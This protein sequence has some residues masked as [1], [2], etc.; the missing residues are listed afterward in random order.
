MRTALEFDLT[1]QLLQPHQRISVPSKRPMTLLPAALALL[2]AILGYLDSSPLPLWMAIFPAL[3]TGLLDP[4]RLVQ[5]LAI[6]TPIFPVLR[7]ASD[8]VGAQQVSTK[9]LFFSADD[10]LILALAISWAWSRLRQ[11]REAV[12]LFPSALLALFALYPLVIGA[13]LMR[14]S[15]DQALVSGLYYIKWAEYAIL[16][17]AIPQVIPESETVRL[18]RLFFKTTLAALCISTVFASYEFAEALRTGSYSVS[19]SFP[20]ASAFFGTLDPQRFGASEDPVNFGTYAMVRGAIAFSGLVRSRSGK[21]TA[22]FFAVVCGIVALL[23]SASRAPWL[24]ALAA[25]GKIRKIRSSRLVL[26]ALGLLLAGTLLVL[27][28]PEVWAISAS[29]FTALGDWQDASESSAVDRLTIAMNSPVFQFDQYWILGHGHSSYR[30]IAEEH[31]SRIARGVSRSLY[32]FP[33]TVWYDVGAAGC[34]LWVLFFH[35]LNRRLSG[36]AETCPDDEV[37]TFASGIRGAFWGIAVAA[38]FGEVPYNW[39]VMGVFYASAGVCLAADLRSR[40][41]FFRRPG[42][43]G[44]N[45]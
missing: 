44:L 3:W 31:L 33:L 19:A 14:L 21:K 38:M 26:S 4:A 35:Q 9:G 13:N 34:F 40:R 29:R 25:F 6:T 22:A 32:N 12:E 1:R 30:F 36:I 24:S 20:R 42:Y 10:P 41:L 5:M 2:L 11:T 8:T 16:I 39:R 7:M 15:V 28:L 23:L 18:Q 45:P 17:L 27:L 43:E 37:R